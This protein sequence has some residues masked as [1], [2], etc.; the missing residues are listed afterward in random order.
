MI[1]GILLCATLALYASVARL[2]VIELIVYIGFWVV[3]SII[4]ELI[5]RP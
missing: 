5:K 1:L 4:A 2:S 3:A